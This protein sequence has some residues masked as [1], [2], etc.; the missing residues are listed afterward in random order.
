MVCLKNGSRKLEQS[1]G[2]GTSGEEWGEVKMEAQ[3]IPQK[4]LRTTFSRCD[5]LPEGTGNHLQAFRGD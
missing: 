5:F 3:I 4:A 1:G 2:V